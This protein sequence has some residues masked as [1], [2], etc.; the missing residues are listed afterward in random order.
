M[1]A[2]LAGTQETVP[3]PHFMAVKLEIQEKKHD[4][5]KTTQCVSGRFYLDF[6][7]TRFVAGLGEQV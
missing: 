7:C 4:L 2:I 3:T 6:A 5:S 1:T